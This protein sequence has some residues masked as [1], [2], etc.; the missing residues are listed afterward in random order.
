MNTLRPSSTLAPTSTG[1]EMPYSLAGSRDV[2]RQGDHKTYVEE[3]YRS[4]NP[5]YEKEVENPNFSLSGNFPHTVRPFMLRKDH[6]GKQKPVGVH[7]DEKGETERAPQVENTDARANRTEEQR[8]SGPQGSSQQSETDSE[9]HAVGEENMTP[10]PSE[11]TIVPDP[12]FDAP[13]NF[14]AAFRK[15][16]QDPLGEWLGVSLP[17]D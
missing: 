12:A 5:E 15:K 9:G 6:N 13:F 3:G 11:N 16:Y 17:D 4:L 2:H 1:R 7:K 14:W 8:E 10:Y